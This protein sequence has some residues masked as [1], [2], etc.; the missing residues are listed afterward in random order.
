MEVEDDAAELLGGVGVGKFFAELC[1][2]GEEV[3]PLSGGGFAGKGEEVGAVDLGGVGWLGFEAGGEGFRGLYEGGVVEEG[4]RLLG[5]FDWKRST[6][7]SSREG[8]SKA[9]SMG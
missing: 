2:E 3:F 6:A 4:E 1:E 5:E 7:H 8:A 9:A